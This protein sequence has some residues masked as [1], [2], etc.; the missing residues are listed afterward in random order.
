MTFKD[1]ST[2][3]YLGKNY[4]RRIRSGDEVAEKIELINGQFLVYL[5]GL[6]Y[7]KKNYLRQR[8]PS[9]IKKL[10]YTPKS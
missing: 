1:G 4:P 9:W 8:D 5:N 10:N 6:K 3:P 7:S 2:L